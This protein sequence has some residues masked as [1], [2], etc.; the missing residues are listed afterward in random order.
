MK[1]NSDWYAE[2]QKKL[3]AEKKALQA[4]LDQLLEKFTLAELEKRFLKNFGCI[5]FKSDEFMHE[6]KLARAFHE[7]HMKLYPE[8]HDLHEYEKYRCYH[9]TTCKCGFEEAAD[10]S[11]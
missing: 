1:T 5:N 6:L 10:S 9:I 7:F 3:E 8:L 2:L 4:E 11:D